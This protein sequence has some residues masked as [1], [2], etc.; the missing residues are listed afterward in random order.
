MCT[1]KIDSNDTAVASVF[2]KTACTKIGGG[3]GRRPDMTFLDFW[4]TSSDLYEP[5]EG[6]KDAGTE[7]CRMVISACTG[8]YC[9]LGLCGNFGPQKRFGNG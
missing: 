5:D 1:C 3:S 6:P 7:F 9:L 8:Q 2:F 4:S